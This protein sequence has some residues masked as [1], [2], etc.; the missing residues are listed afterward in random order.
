MT[1]PIRPPQQPAQR[2]GQ[3]RAGAL[4]LTLAGL[5]AM[6]LGCHAST[7][8]APDAPA[9]RSAEAFDELPADLEAVGALLR[10]RHADD[11]PSAD[12]L[13]R[14]ASA[15]ASLRHY[16][17]E[18]DTMLVRVRALSLLQHFDSEATASLLVALLSEPDI[19]GALRAAAVSGSA[20][21]PLEDRPELLGLLSSALREDDPRVG[22]AAVGALSHCEAGREALRAANEAELSQPAR[23]ALLELEI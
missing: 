6:S 17:R 11:L 4:A 2:P 5:C 9:Q 22:V 10:A 15:E 13:G 18:G 3:R 21:Q 1:R 23:D 20:G 7:E 14:Y 8:E 12:D 16:A 19:H